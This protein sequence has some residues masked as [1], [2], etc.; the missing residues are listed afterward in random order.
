MNTPTPVPSKEQSSKLRMHLRVPSA[1]I[2][3]N[4]VLCG[5]PATWTHVTQEVPAVTCERCLSL[6]AKR[7]A[8]EPRARKCVANMA[9]D[10]PQDCDAPFCGCNPAW[11]DCIKMLQE[12]DLIIDRNAPRPASLEELRDRAANSPGGATVEILAEDVRRLLRTSQPP[13]VKHPSS[14]AIHGAIWGL[15]KDWTEDSDVNSVLT[16]DV[17]DAVMRVLNPSLTKSA[18]QSGKG[19]EEAFSNEA[20]SRRDE[21]QG[22]PSSS[23]GE[24]VKS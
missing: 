15:L 23:Q 6:L 10:P 7:T 1:D 19:M 8:H 4:E 12:C 9:S 24:E 18:D 21:R 5:T 13:A 17:H 22:L 3:V 11:D 16:D 2:T 14:D 20:M